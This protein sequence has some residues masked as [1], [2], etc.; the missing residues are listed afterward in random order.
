MSLVAAISS[1]AKHLAAFAPKGGASA[2]HH[3]KSHLMPLLFSFGFLGVFLVSIVDS[4]FVPLPLPGVTDIM[5]IVMAAQHQNWILLVL[6]ATA[7]SALGGYFS[8]QVGQ[9]GGMAF[10]EKH[11][12]PKIFKRVCEW[13]ENHAILSV[14]LPA[15]LPPPMPLSPFVLAAGALKMSRKKFLIAFTLSR[16][17][18]HAVAAWLGIHYGRH[19]LHLWNKLSAKYAVPV[20]IV[21]WTV[22]LVSCAIA[23]WKLYKTSRTVGPHGTAVTNPAN[24]AV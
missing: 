15:I 5:V 2:Q 10:L 11:V 17:V 4:S 1:T 13:M 7:G 19:I 3:G 9:S 21:L 18:R 8:Y 6:A 20:L 16:A 12:P 22:I 24:T 14:A 23:F